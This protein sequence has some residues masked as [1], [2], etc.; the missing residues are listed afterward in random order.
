MVPY[1]L[2]MRSPCEL[3]ERREEL[4]ARAAENE[5][6]GPI[7]NCT[8]AWAHHLL[9]PPLSLGRGKKL[10]A[11]RRDVNSIGRRNITSCT[12]LLV[13]PAVWVLCH[14]TV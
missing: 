5:M 13:L 11:R 14:L 6:Y 9:S 3:Q 1:E 7:D 8:Q 2:A 4:C 10:A 12:Q